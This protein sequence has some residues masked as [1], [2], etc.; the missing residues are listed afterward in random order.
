MCSGVN[1]GYGQNEI[2]G[3]WGLSTDRHNRDVYVCGCAA[4]RIMCLADLIAIDKFSS[5][6]F[7][8]LF[9]NYSSTL[10]GSKISIY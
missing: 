6:F 5:I 1:R 2:L 10:R 9:C 4:D 7:D 8:C 3:P